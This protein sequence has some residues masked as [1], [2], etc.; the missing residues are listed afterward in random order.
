[1]TEDS[2]LLG[3][4]ECA[5]LLGLPRRRLRGH[6]ADLDGIA[7]GRDRHGRPLFKRGD[8]YR[9]AA[10][11]L[12]PGFGPLIPLEYWGRPD[13]PAVFAG[14]RQ[15][16]AAVALT[17]ETS[18]GLVVLAWDYP[19][20]RVRTLD[21]VLKEFP[22]AA[23]AAAAGEDFGHDGPAVW[24][25]LPGNPAAP[26]YEPGWKPLSDAL[27]VPLPYW[28]VPLRIPELILG[29]KPGSPQVTAAA[30]TVLDL[31]APLRL[32]A[33]ADPGSPAAQTM[34]NL[35]RTVQ[36]QAAE[37]TFMALDIAERTAPPGTMTVA[38][39]PLKIPETSID[40]LDETTRK[41]GWLD[42]LDRGD[43]LAALAAR[44]IIDWDA[45]SDFPVGQPE[46]ID[47]AAPLGQEWAARLVRVPR[48]AAAEILDPRQEAAEILSD[49]E[50][51]APVIRDADGILVAASPRRL[52]TVSPLAELIL[53]HPV[54][55]RTEDG[56]LYPAPQDHYCG[57]GWGYRG[58]DSP[59]AL[60]FLIHRLL[61]DITAPAADGTGRAPAGLE[62]LTE[63][64][65]PDGTVFT[66]RQLEDARRGILP[67][68]PPGQP[69][70]Q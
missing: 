63:T 50:T 61:D 53:G 57:I 36:W 18:R 51:G 35:A 48:T 10:R 26:V 38:A 13:G 9:W 39:V 3:L 55:V 54:W 60:A 14:S 62:Q 34:L 68:P 46:E 30:R 16:D 47:P 2:G 40:D 23:A 58:G 17:W 52:P 70:E 43:H 65:W 25:K 7:A 4:G 56:T 5:A 45:G 33:L 28:P 24:A 42:I 44:R 32:A 27:G 69:D 49:P 22:G 8:F 41:A 67:S 37:S 12:D 29:W 19:P 1:M 20:N 31:G 64:R 15:L 66:R 11:T 6:R 21:T 59:A